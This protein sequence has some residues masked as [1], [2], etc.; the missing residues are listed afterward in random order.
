MDAREGNEGYGQ[1]TRVVDELH[2]L[3]KKHARINQP[4]GEEGPAYIHI[5]AASALHVMHFE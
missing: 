1:A 2:R 3:N 5:V 4:P